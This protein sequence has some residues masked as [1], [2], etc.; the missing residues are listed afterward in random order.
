MTETTGIRQ[1]VLTPDYHPTAPSRSIFPEPA[2][3]TVPYKRKILDRWTTRITA[4]GLPGNQLV[5]AYLHGKYIKNLSHRTI[6][7]AGGVILAFMHFLNKE[8]SSILALTRGDIGA[9]VEGEQD[10][11]LKT[12]SIISHL[13]VVYA[14][15]NYLVDQEIVPPEIMN[16]K[17]RMQ[18]PDALPKAI[19]KEDINRILDA[20]ASVRDRALIMLLLRTGM[21]IGELLEVKVADILLHDQKIL[22]YVGSKNYEGREVYY[23]ADA[24]QALKQ[25]LRTRDKTRRYLF[26][27]RSDKPLTYASAWNAMRKTLK[28]A[29]LLDKGY[30]PHSLRHTFATDM[31]NAGMHV[32]V[33][34][35]ILGHQDI[36]MTLR[37]ARLSDQRKEEDYYRAMAVIQRRG[38]SDEPYRVS[39]ALQK[40]FEEKK[41]L[42]PHKKKLSE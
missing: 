2:S 10:R 9:F 30:S 26:Y 19:P 16:P 4:S 1:D 12:V 31:I 35:Q 6:D 37:Y 20:I 34:Q 25:W 15:I 7:H 41:L 8:S 42:Q 11:G 40:V 33:L 21:R 39:T 5:T 27:G 24:E 28:R 32:E 3:E 23:S 29:D 14:F 17:I 38:E 18:E 36:E 13:R 22:L